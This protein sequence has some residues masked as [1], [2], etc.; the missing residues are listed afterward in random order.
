MRFSNKKDELCQILQCAKE[1]IAHSKISATV[2]TQ[3][4]TN[5]G[6]VGLWKC[7]TIKTQTV[8][9]ITGSEKMK[10][11]NIR[12]RKKIAKIRHTR[13]KYDKNLDLM[14]DET[15]VQ[16]ATRKEINR[17]IAKV[18]LGEIPSTYLCAIKGEIN[19]ALWKQKQEKLANGTADTKRARK[20]KARTQD[21]SFLEKYNRYHDQREKEMG[22]SVE[23]T[24]EYED[25]I[26]QQYRGI[27]L[28]HIG[29]SRKQLR[30]LWRLALP[31][32]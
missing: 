1:Q 4:Q 22:E 30:Q 27:M 14:Y 8:V 6:R 3:S 26:H 20:R 2:P 18:A 5:I 10:Q 12:L 16:T 24:E 29:M 7:H 17:I 32:E 23:F 25:R 19:Y 13:T 21:K 15:G 31:K 9:S 11:E 28:K